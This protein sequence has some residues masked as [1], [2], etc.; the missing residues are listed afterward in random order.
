MTDPDITRWSN[1]CGFIV[2][3]HFHLFLLLSFHLTAMSLL[4]KWF[5]FKCIWNL[6]LVTTIHWP[7]FIL[8]ECF[9]SSLLSLSLMSSISSKNYDTLCFDRIINAT[10]TDLH[11][12]LRN[13]AV[14]KL[15]YLILKVIH[16]N[17]ASKSVQSCLS[18]RSPFF[19]QNICDSPPQHCHGWPWHNHVSGI[20]MSSLTW[21]ETSLCASLASNLLFGFFLHM[22]G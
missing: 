21:Y 19:S 18:H 22:P 12:T 17:L 10:V 11:A 6:P 2:S 9:S 5:I 3:F 20:L 7:Q 8:I 1:R 4:C 14:C 16:H 13:F 15:I